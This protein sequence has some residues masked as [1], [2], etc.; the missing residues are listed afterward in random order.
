MKETPDSSPGK[1]RA[2]LVAFIRREV[3]AK[4]KPLRVPW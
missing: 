1:V 3:L 4:L 2:A